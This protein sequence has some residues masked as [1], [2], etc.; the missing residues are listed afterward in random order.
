MNGDDKKLALEY[1]ELWREQHDLMAKEVRRD[2]KSVIEKLTNLPCKARQIGT[3]YIKV[4]IIGL[5][6]V[7]GWIVFTLV[8]KYIG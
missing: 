6:T 3:D 2:L 5:Y 1:F 4:S 7:V 8:R